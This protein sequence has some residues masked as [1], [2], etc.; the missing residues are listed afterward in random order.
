MT[1][2]GKEFGYIVEVYERILKFRGGV[3]TQKG[4]QMKF[5]ALKKSRKL[6]CYECYESH[7]KIAHIHFF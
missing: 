5:M 4:K 7:L 1:E 6:R 2:W 3:S